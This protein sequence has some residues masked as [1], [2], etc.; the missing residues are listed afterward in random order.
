MPKVYEQISR[1]RTKVVISLLA[2]MSAANIANGGR[3]K[4]GGKAN[5]RTELLLLYDGIFITEM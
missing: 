4:I 3:R 5:K 2:N 1:T